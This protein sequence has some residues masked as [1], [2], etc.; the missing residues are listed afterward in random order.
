[1]SEEKLE[2]FSNILI[3][4]ADSPYV[5]PSK[6]GIIKKCYLKDSELRNP[7]NNEVGP[8]IEYFI[9]E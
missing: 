3:T 7:K 2:V 9:K 1:M 4:I 6:P 5:H 8:P